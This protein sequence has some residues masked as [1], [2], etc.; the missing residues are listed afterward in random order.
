MGCTGN[1]LSYGC[2]IIAFGLLSSEY[3]GILCNICHAVWQQFCYFHYSFHDKLIVYLF[4][5]VPE[6]ITVGT[7]IFVTWSVSLAFGM[8]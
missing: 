6:N 2:M 1:V 5:F 3:N 4:I 8:F 7:V